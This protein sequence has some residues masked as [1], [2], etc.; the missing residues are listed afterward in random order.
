MND[1]N[2]NTE[3]TNALPLGDT[4]IVK[5]HNLEPLPL[6]T[7]IELRAFTDGL[8]A[9]MVGQKKTKSELLF[10]LENYIHT[11]R[12]PNVMFIAGKGQGKTFTATETAKGLYEFN[13][14]GKVG[15]KPSASDP[16]IVK[17]VRKRFVEI[18]CATLKTVKQFINGVIIPYVQDKDVTIFFDEASEIP[19]PVAMALLTILPVN[20][21][22]SEFT[23]EEYTCTFDFKR[24]TF[25]FATTESQK[26]FPPLMDRLERITLQDYTQ[27]E[28]AEILRRAL[29]K[30]LKTEPEATMEVASVLRGNARAAEKM[31]DKIGSFMRTSEARSFGLPEWEALRARLSILPLGLNDIELNILRY[32]ANAPEGTSLTR[33]AA[34]TGMSRDALQKTEEVYLQ[35]HDLM[36]ITTTGRKITAKGLDYLRT[37]DGATKTA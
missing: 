23:Y 13:E 28:L 30:T 17:P 16:N 20:R 22:T 27:A 24:Q 29:P 6:C 18:N 37:Y 19:H 2:H 7:D 8:F 36:E 11:R 33:L 12:F 4:V 3:F 31:A 25:M 34:K 1:N 14:D 10:H 32:L 35:R 15:K 21:M 26:V 5:E 9:D